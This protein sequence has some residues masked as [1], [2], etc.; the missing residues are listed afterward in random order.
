MVDTGAASSVI[1]ASLL[2][3]RNVF[4]VSRPVTVSS[5]IDGKILPIIGEV[6]LTIKYRHLIVGVTSVKVIRNSILP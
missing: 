1:D 2:K 4:A 3:G 6:T 5:G